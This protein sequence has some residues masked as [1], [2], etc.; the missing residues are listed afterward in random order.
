MANDIGF[1]PEC[2]PVPLFCQFIWSCNHNMDGL[3]SSYAESSSGKSENHNI[4]DH[5]LHGISFVV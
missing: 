2:L 5:V 1:V 3:T 4:C